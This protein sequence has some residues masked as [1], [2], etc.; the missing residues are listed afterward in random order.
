MQFHPASR[1]ILRT[2]GLATDHTPRNC[3]D[4]L[5]AHSH[6]QHPLPLPC[7][8]DASRREGCSGHLSN[9]PLRQTV[10]F[11][12][13]A[14]PAASPLTSV[15]QGRSRLLLSY[16]ASRFPRKVSISDGSLKRCWAG[17]GAGTGAEVPAR[18][19][20]RGQGTAGDGEG[21]QSPTAAPP[22]Q[23]RKPGRA[24]AVWTSTEPYEDAAT[25]QTGGPVPRRERPTL[26]PALPL[27]STSAGRRALPALPRGPRRR[28]AAAP[29]PPGSGCP[30]VAHGRA[31][32]GGA[33][34]RGGG[35]T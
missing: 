30:Q 21:L 8:K 32:P 33:G 18:V 12:T 19:A 20:A 31:A 15:L 7:T 3:Q 5:G 29:E 2:E 6:F 34:T 9:T 14:P 24:A 10:R 28:P 26:P 23:R 17:G 4:Q 16:Q 1:F 13:T 35:A 22:G 27:P 11:P 25:S